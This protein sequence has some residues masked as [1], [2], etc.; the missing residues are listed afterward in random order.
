[1]VAHRP[2]EING[3]PREQAGEPCEAIFLS[4]SRNLSLAT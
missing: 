2:R 1:M 4:P 3:G